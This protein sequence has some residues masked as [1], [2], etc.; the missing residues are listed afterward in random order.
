MPSQV[1]GRLTAPHIFDLHFTLPSS[2]NLQESPHLTPI[3]TGRLSATPQA[4]CKIEDE[5]PQNQAHVSGQSEWSSLFHGG[6]KA[7]WSH[8]VRCGPIRSDPDPVTVLSSPRCSHVVVPSAPLIRSVAD[9]S[10]R[11]SADAKNHTAPVAVASGVSDHREISLKAV[12]YSNISHLYYLQLEIEGPTKGS[13][14]QELQQGM[15][16]FCTKTRKHTGRFMPYHCY[17]TSAAQRQLQ[18]L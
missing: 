1:H 5:L 12:T 9:P 7:I 11:A 17:K 6:W 16:L 13:A 15:H 14:V 4:S 8:P 3:N 10:L 18:G 2:G